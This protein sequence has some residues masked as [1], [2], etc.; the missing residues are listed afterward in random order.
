[1]YMRQKGFLNIIIAIIVGAVIIL[2]GAYVI[3]RRSGQPVAPE[4]KLADQQSGVQQSPAE[5]SPQQNAI[6]KKERFKES[7]ISDFKPPSGSGQPPQ[8]AQQVGLWPPWLTRLMTAVSADGLNWTR[9]NQVVTDQGDVPDLTIDKNGR[10][11]L[12]YLGWTVGNQQNVTVVA[13]SD[14]KGKTWVY[15]KLKLIGFENMAPPTDPDIQIL[16]DGTFRLY[17]T[18]QELS[19]QPSSPQPYTYYA[20][21]TDGIT[22]TKRGV[23]FQPSG[24]LAMDPSI[25]LVGST[26]HYFAGGIPGVNWHATSQDGKSFTL[27]S[28]RTFTIGGQKYLMANGIPVEGGARFY[29]FFADRQGD[30]NIASFFSSDGNTWTADP[31]FRLTLDTSN[32]KES[33]GVKDPSVIKLQDGTYLMVYVTKIP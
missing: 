27:E 31:G 12:Y 30:V 5:Q 20:E 18:S 13:M 3:V 19:G 22:F 4:P 33:V 15:K 9:T 1:M 7:L 14:N 32:G 2:G 17:L 11:Y 28:Q 29:A 21:G 25:V 10:I 23:A 26:W 16:P 6:P 24:G 8:G